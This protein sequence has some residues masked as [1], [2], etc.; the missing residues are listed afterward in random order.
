MARATEEL[1]AEQLQLLILHL[2][3]A[4]AEL[5]DRQTPWLL[6][7]LP[8]AQVMSQAGAH[9]LLPETALDGVAPL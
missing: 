9:K 6:L 7:E 1:K 2:F 5:F 3:L 4:D 8:T